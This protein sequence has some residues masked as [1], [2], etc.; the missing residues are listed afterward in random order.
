MKQTMVYNTSLR[1]PYRAYMYMDRNILLYSFH[2]KRKYFHNFEL[3]YGGY[4]SLVMFTCINCIFMVLPFP[5]FDNEKYIY[6]N[7]EN[8]IVSKLTTPLIDFYMEN[9]WVE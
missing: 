4:H 9:E 7:S 5:K 2:F 1:L 8:S 6:L 3:Y